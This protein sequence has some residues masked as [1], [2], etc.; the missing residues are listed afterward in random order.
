MKNYKQDIADL[1]VKVNKLEIE[2]DIM[3]KDILKISYLVFII[4]V[5]NAICFYILT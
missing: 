1:N 2:I 3:K 5:I 4:T